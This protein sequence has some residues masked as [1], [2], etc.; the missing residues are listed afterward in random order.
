L[1]FE[2]KTPYSRLVES[3]LAVSLYCPPV[4]PNVVK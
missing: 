4:Q 1:D 2:N 3:G